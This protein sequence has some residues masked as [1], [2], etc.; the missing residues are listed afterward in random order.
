MERVALLVDL[1][2][3]C[4]D[5]G[6]DLGEQRRGEPLPR[7][8]TSQLVEQRPTHRCWGV[9]VGLGPFLNYLEHGRTITNQRANAGP[10]RGAMDSRS[11]SGRSVPSCHQAEVH[12]QVLIVA[13]M[14]G[15]E[16][17]A[18]AWVWAQAP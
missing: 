5:V 17:P 6:G 14:A 15:G 12:P 3:V 13:L 1:V 7:V 11:S 10:D 4:I 9:L 8:V 16:W 18:L 2:A